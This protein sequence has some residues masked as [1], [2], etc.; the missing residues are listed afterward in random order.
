MMVKLR[1][2]LPKIMQEPKRNKRNFYH[3]FSDCT[4]QFTQYTIDDT[5]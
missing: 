3:I 5:R 4:M 1:V 2:R